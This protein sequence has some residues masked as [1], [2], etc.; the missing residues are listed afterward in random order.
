VPLSFT[1]VF[2]TAFVAA[3]VIAILY[4]YWLIAPVL[5][6]LNVNQW[7]LIAIVVAAASGCVLSLFRLPM[8]PLAS[9]SL[10]GLLVGGTYAAWQAPSDARMSVIAAVG[11]HLQSFWREVTLLT[12][13]ITLSALCCARVTTRRPSP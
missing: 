5:H 4:R 12:V 6:Y 7:R 9:A 2:P 10:A 3:A 11:S 8:L 13:I 1:R